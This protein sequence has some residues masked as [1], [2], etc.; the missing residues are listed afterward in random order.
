MLMTPTQRTKLFE[1]LFV[2]IP[3]IFFNDTT[4]C[5][6][7]TGKS[8]WSFQCNRQSPEKKSIKKL[9]PKQK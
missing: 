1:F 7:S 8:T 4:T 2:G 9:K 3:E 5:V 6:R